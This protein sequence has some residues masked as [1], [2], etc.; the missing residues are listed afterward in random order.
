LFYSTIPH[1]QDNPPFSI[2]Q[3]RHSAA[4]LEASPSNHT[5]NRAWFAIGHQDGQPFKNSAFRVYRDMIDFTEIPN[6]ETWELF[7]RDF[8]MERGFYIQS[9]PDRGA[10]AGKDMLVTEQLSGILGTYRFRWLVSCKH[11]AVSGKAVNE[12]DERNLLER[13]ES[14][15][16]DGFMGFYST[17]PTAGWNT[18]LTA[19][20][21]SGKLADYRVFDHRLV[22]EDL[23]RV[24]HSFLLQRYFPNSYREIK[25]LN[26]LFAEYLPLPCEVCHRDLLTD[27][28]EHREG[29]IVAFVY[30]ENSPFEV[31]DIYVACKGNC[32]QK[33]NK[34]Y[35]EE[36]HST[37]WQSLGDLVVPTRFLQ[38][39]MSKMN[40]MRTER[41]KF[42]DCAYG[43]F[44]TLLLALSQKVLRENTEK[45]FDRMSELL[46]VDSLIK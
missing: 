41:E 10:D 36:G 46:D 9:P 35:G 5:W 1:V 37:G 31:N 15:G 33:L 22:E 8:L 42:T 40:L 11:N 18:R 25:P 2:A 14:F 20:K 27:L 7:A 30:G 34:R 23:V 26:Q 13:M 44:Q 21:S 16:A 24:G 17:V 28:Y 29:G 6:G 38:F 19:L 32:D 39:W 43:K 12:E 45:D 4:L 3:N